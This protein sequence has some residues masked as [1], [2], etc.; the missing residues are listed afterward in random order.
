MFYFFTVS[1]KK[2][3]LHTVQ[4]H[5]IEQE[6]R[7][8]VRRKQPK[9]QVRDR[10]GQAGDPAGPLNNASAFNK[11][12]RVALH[13]GAL[14]LFSFTSVVLVQNNENFTL[15]IVHWNIQAHKVE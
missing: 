1:L 8:Y 3:K 5:E 11:A 6:K 9:Q 12:I 14:W 2:L 7:L 13:R 4:A 10:T 15:N